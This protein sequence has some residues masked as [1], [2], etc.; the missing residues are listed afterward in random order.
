MVTSEA[1]AKLIA[2]MTGIAAESITEQESEKLLR[3]EA[4]LGEQV[5]GQEKAVKAVSEA[6]RCSRAGLNDPHRPMASFLFLGPSGVG[7]TQLCKVL[8]KELFSSEEAMIRLDMSEFA[9]EHMAARL[10][11]APPGYVGYQEGGRL[12]EAVRKKPYSL[13]LFDESEK[14]HP[15][16]CDLLLQILED[17]QLEDGEGKRISFRSCVIVMTS[18]IGAEHFRKGGG[19]GFGGQSESVSHELAA[20]KSRDELKKQFRPEF[21][22]RIDE[23]LVFRWLGQEAL[24]SICRQLL[25]ELSRRLKQQNLTLQVSEKAI[26]QLCKEGYEPQLGARPLRRC[27][28]RR[29]EQPLSAELLSGNY[30]AGDCIVC[31]F[32]DNLFVFSVAG[33][34]VPDETEQGK[35][36]IAFTC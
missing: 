31:D 33:K 10:I 23:I 5:V 18:N 22:N 28:R 25:N 9:Q 34:I 19:I 21:I 14:A 29:I 4:A 24:Q 26:H 12:T 13:I 7:K 17:G 27:I 35:T 2:R 3:M 11:D 1:V 36:Q 16:V 15:R 32:V 30:R 8:A 6:I 20:A